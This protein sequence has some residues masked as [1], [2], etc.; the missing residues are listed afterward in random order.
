MKCA[1]ID[2]EMKDGFVRHVGQQMLNKYS[3]EQL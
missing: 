3:I 2:S 1:Q